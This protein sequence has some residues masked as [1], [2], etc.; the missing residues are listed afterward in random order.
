M[1]DSILKLQ[2]TDGIFDYS[3]SSDPSK[4]TTEQ[5]YIEWTKNHHSVLESAVHV[6][7][8]QPDT[9]YTVGMVVCSPNMKGNTVARVTTAGHSSAAEPAWTSAGNSV[10]DG[11]VVWLMVPRTLDFAT[12][13]ELTAGTVADKLVSPKTLNTIMDTRLSPKLNTADLTPNMLWNVLH[14]KGT[15]FKPSDVTNTGWSAL[16]AFISYYNSNV[17]DNQPSQYGQL[18]NIC[19]NNAN[20][21]TQLWLD[22]SSG[23]LAYRG[24][25]SSIVMNDTAFTYVASATDLANVKS[26]LETTIST[27]S[28]V[29]A[30]NVAN[31]NAWWVKLGGTIPLIIQG[32][33]LSNKKID[34]GNYYDFTFPVSMTPIMGQVTIKYSGGI[35]GCAAAYVSALSNTKATISCDAASSY[36]GSAG[37][38]VLAIGYQ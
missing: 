32:G 22:Q 36:I 29:V 23:K 24:G 21:A 38:Y 30:G 17:I 12:D 8:W 15:N 9:D 10:T 7:L 19:A 33:L 14:S 37:L 1:A 6:S 4:G 3:D 27:K 26:A 11:T 20:E 31:A 16:G 18:I 25:N 2:S 28:G 13:A 35:D 5:E 34:D